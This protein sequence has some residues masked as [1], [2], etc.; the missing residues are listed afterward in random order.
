M[1]SVQGWA[2]EAP[3]Y[4][5]GSDFTPAAAHF[6]QLVWKGSSQMGC[7]MADCGGTRVVVCHFNAPGEAGIP[8]LIRGI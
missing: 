1:E 2:A 8:A 4:A 5:P 3:N 7:G 6:T